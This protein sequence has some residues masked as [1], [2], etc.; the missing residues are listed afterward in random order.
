M[1]VILG[2][3]VLG[4]AW[5]AFAVLSHEVSKILKSSCRR[6]SIGAEAPEQR[7]KSLLAGRRASEYDGGTQPRSIPIIAPLRAA[8]QDRASDS[9]FWPPN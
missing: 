1:R 9:G 4:L 3:N 8:G 2:L 5:G 7:S 6:A